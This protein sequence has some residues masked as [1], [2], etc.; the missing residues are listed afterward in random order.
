ME[1]SDWMRNAPYDL[2]YRTKLE[3]HLLQKNFFRVPNFARIYS[4]NEIHENFFLELSFKEQCV[5]E[6]L[7]SLVAD[8]FTFLVKK[9]PD[10][11][12]GRPK[13]LQAQR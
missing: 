3:R 11:T 4:R 1:Q 5:E 9:G 7:T 8:F 13:P 6:L 2:P 12:S 10:V